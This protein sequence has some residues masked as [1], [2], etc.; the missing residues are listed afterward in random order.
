MV[1]PTS[2]TFLALP[3]EVLADDGTLRQQVAAPAGPD[4]RRQ[5]EVGRAHLGVG[6]LDK[7]KCSHQC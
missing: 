5:A 4:S 6:G 1:L 7:K 2:S 3:P